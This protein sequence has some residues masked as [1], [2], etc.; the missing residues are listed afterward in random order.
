MPDIDVQ[1][2]ISSHEETPSSYSYVEIH[3]GSDDPPPQDR[4]TPRA[5]FDHSPDLEV[6]P[7]TE[8]SNIINPFTDPF[9]N[10]GGR[11]VEGPKFLPPIGT[12][13]HKNKFEA[14]HK[15]KPKSLIHPITQERPHYQHTTTPPYVSKQL[16]SSYYE[17]PPPTSTYPRE[18]FRPPSDSAVRSLGRRRRPAY[19]TKFNSGNL[20]LSNLGS[21]AC[22]PWSCLSLY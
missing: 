15:K 16:T 11:L 14:S 10:I 18:P 1:S 17:E 13:P 3:L 22:I 2:D 12:L 7:V 8:A 19:G 5:V 6:T 20:D 21:Y 9:V 4:S